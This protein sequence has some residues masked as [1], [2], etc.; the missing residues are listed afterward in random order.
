MSAHGPA[1]ARA[2]DDARIAAMLGGM[3]MR[4]S[5]ADPYRMARPTSR[6]FSSST[7]IPSYPARAPSLNRTTSYI[8][9]IRSSSPARPSSAVPG[10]AVRSASPISFAAVRSPSPAGRP[11]LSRMGTASS[12]TE[13]SRA[14][15]PGPYYS[16]PPSQPMT[17]GRLAYPCSGASAPNPNAVRSPFLLKAA[18]LDDLPPKVAILLAQL[19]H[20]FESLAKQYP[21]SSTAI[22]QNQQWGEQL[23][24]WIKAIIPS[25]TSL[26]RAMAQLREISED[27]WRAAGGYIALA[28]TRPVSVDVERPDPEGGT[29]TV[30]V[31]EQL[32]G[33]SSSSI[34]RSTGKMQLNAKLFV[35]TEKK[36][37]VA[38]TKFLKEAEDFVQGLIPVERLALKSAP[39]L[40]GA[41]VPRVPSQQHVRT[42]LQDAV[43]VSHLP[44]QFYQI[45]GPI[46]SDPTVQS[47]VWYN[48]CEARA[49]FKSY[50]RLDETL[51]RAVTQATAAYTFMLENLQRSGY[52]PQD[53]PTSPYSDSAGASA[54][55]RAHTFPSLEVDRAV[56]DARY[57]AASTTGARPV[58]QGV[59]P[60]WAQPI[61][62]GTSARASR[63]RSRTR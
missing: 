9:P 13:S 31:R 19:A 35:E 16:S 48:A 17:P 61:A 27:I 41:S 23:F 54:S 49:V 50:R 51:T 52:L 10:S 55:R 22:Q 53:M 6:S 62:S 56:A 40:P 46:S 30:T 4:A 29:H 36:H 8:A 12:G 47:G 34:S 7:A 57:R 25:F 3:S 5:T 18:A 63:S 20:S 37:N 14:S 43:Q 11:G 26:L 58:S 15:S 60:G 45:L 2:A 38:T 1:Y 44:R 42:L 32:Q 28:E 21:V 24:A 59:G 33:V 39:P